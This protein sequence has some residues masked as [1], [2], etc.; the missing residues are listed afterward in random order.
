VIR[1]YVERSGE[2]LPLA[3]EE[4]VGAA[5]AMGGRAAPEG[6]EFEGLAAVELPDTVS[7]SDLAARLALAH[8]CLVLPSATGEVS[9]AAEAAGSRGE[10]AAFRRL[11]RPTA[12]DDPVLHAVARR[13]VAAGGRIDLDHP[14]ARW[15]I[16]TDRDGRDRLLEEA[17]AV[18]RAAPA[19]R[20]MPLLPFQ[21]PVSL[22]PRL[23]RAAANLARVRPGSRVLDPFLGTGALLGEAGLLGGR[24]YG[25]DRDA[26]M[27]Q[28]ALRN[29]E[30]LGV[31]AE[32]LVAG[33]A[34][35]VDFPGR[36]GG[37]DAILTDPPYGRSSSTGGE[38]ADELVRRVVPRWGE[39]V[40]PGGFVVLVV[41]TGASEL[42]APWRLRSSVSV[43]V[44]RSL[45][46]EFRV[47]ARTAEVPS[48]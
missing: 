14:T 42:P 2:S 17:G 24:L 33:D 5:E 38:P 6:S 43:R 7:P 11:G 48:G 22:P 28:G 4:A 40:G 45:T 39:R 44:H 19:R 3:T 9:A 32:E 25:I 20:R 34:G 21:R 10:G 13:Y 18:D 27:V 15:W 29:L 1:V 23:A 16:A 12:G 36:P 46:R 30:F 26:T 41:P 8:R 37:F 31:R 35:A 47:Y